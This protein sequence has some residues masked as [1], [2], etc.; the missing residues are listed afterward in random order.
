MLRR[1]RILAAAALVVAAPTAALAARGY[2]TDAVKMRAG[3]GTE[4]PVVTVIPDSAR[5]NIHGCLSDID[6]CDV[7]WSGDRGWVSANYLN[8]YYGNRF[9]Y[10]PDYADVIGVPIVT[11]SFDSYWNNYY[12]GRPWYHNR[13]HWA[14][15]WRHHRQAHQHHGRGHHAGRPGHQHHA[16]PVHRGSHVVHRGL[17]ARH[18]FGSHRMPRSFGH[19]SRGHQF[20]MHRGRMHGFRGH[21]AAPHFSGRAMGG[22]RMGGRAMGHFGGRGPGMAAHAMGHGGRGGM[23][24]HGRGG[25]GGRRGHR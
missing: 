2:A 24:G 25:G 20:G 13:S 1:W 5:V 23:A 8:Y 10:L 17:P 15:Y 11:F 16:A 22:H 19:V 21:A 18:H 4:Y 7:T 12:V 6:W 14:R 9:V 3:P